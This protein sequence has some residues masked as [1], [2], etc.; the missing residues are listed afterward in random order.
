M[1]FFINSADVIGATFP[2][3]DNAHINFNFLSF[4]DFLS[5]PPGFEAKSI[6]KTSFLTYSNLFSFKTICGTVFIIISYFTFHSK[7]KHI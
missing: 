3:R 4:T 7:K 5:I 6:N 2:G 1:V